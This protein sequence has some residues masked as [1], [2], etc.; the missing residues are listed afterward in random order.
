MRQVIHLLRRWPSLLLVASFVLAVAPAWSF[1]FSFAASLTILIGRM[2]GIPHG[3][4]VMTAGI[5]G[6]AGTLDLLAH[7]EDQRSFHS[8]G[9]VEASSLVAVAPQRDQYLV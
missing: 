2:I 1:A 7:G 6:T 9:N 8:Q 5:V 4:Y 3:W